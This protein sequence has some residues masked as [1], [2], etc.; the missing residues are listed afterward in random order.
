MEIGG[1]IEFEHYTRPMLHE[2]A[3]ALNSGRGALA[4]LI[5]V[6]NIR[7]LALPRFLCDSVEN[8]CAR[9][10]VRTRFY[11]VDERF[12]PCALDLQ[13]DEWLYLLNAYGQLTGEKLRQLCAVYDRVILDNAQSYFDAPP[14]GVDTLYTCRKFFGVPDGAFLYTDAVLEEEMP[15][16]ES[17]EHMR[18]LLGRFER[19]ASEFYEEYV[20]N[21]RR[22]AHEPVK[23]MSKLTENLLRAVDYED[24]KQRRTENFRTLAD[25]L[26]PFNRLSLRVPEGAFAYPLWLENGA[27]VRQKLIERKI[28]IPTLWPNVLRD[29]PPDSLACALA[30]DILPLP[31]DQRYAE[32]EMRIIIDAVLNAAAESGKEG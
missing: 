8:L 2:G 1:Y 13:P 30:R 28:F 4:Y 23:R 24:V 5:R 17:F 18:F 25:A 10:G 29:A 21:N 27:A 3:L 6:K 26:G 14:E 22:F 19:G 12:M 32:R 20:E 7:A 9:K 15:R 31:V 11:D 16:D